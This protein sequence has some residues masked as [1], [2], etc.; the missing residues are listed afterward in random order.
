MEEG[1]LT[2]VELAVA[3]LTEFAATYGLRVLGAILVLLA[4]WWLAKRLGKAS[5]RAVENNDHL[6]STLGPMAERG[7][8]GALLVLT[9]VIVLGQFGVETASIIAV[10]GAA[11]LAIGLALQG[12]LSNV[13]AGIVMLVVKPM[14]VDDI[15]LVN[16]ERGVVVQIGFLA[17]KIRTFD[18]RLVTMP[19]TSAWEGN[20]ENW[21][22]LDRY[23][24]KLSFGVGYG[25]DLVE[26]V[27]IIRQTIEDEAL[28]LPDEPLLV[29]VTGHGDNAIL[30]EARPWVHP[31]DILKATY[32]IMMEAKQRL[33]DAGISIPFPQRDVHV[34]A[35]DR[36]V[37][38]W[39][40][41][42]ASNGAGTG[43]RLDA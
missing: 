15:V 19:N 12:T 2:G 6:D 42:G 22:Y 26:S 13:A 36:K 28:V 3:R 34:F 5:R 17:T 14:R 10:L 23:R 43:A 35:G 1:D 11:G 40:E 41:A 8:R 39:F 31:Q 32:A 27:R 38:A 24:L 7:T 21:S 33:D 25:A 20:I 18:G 30:I 29:G 37:A 4:G 9:G 16:G